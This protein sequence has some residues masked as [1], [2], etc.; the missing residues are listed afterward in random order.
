[1]VDAST[2]MFV[3]HEE[4]PEEQI[5]ELRTTL[6]GKGTSGTGLGSKRLRPSAIREG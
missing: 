6:G 4:L 3:I 1:M 2:H 5:Q